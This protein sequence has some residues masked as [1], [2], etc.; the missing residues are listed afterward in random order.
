MP[1]K[2]KLSGHQKGNV[3]IE[4][5]GTRPNS[6][7]SSKNAPDK[8]PWTWS[9]EKP[10]SLR[11]AELEILVSTLKDV[12]KFK[13]GIHDASNLEGDRGFTRW[14]SGAGRQK[15][16][17]RAPF[18]KIDTARQKVA[19]QNIMRQA[20]TMPRLVKP[21]GYGFDASEVGT[22]MSVFG[23]RYPHESSFRPPRSAKSSSRTLVVISKGRMKCHGMPRQPRFRS[24]PCFDLLEA[25]RDW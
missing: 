6:S 2:Q 3:D 21:V 19:L 18:I 14:K 10:A 4:S 13:N 8:L 12:E 7:R 5:E 24:L 15:D 9:K 17:K 1:A 23:S 20:K 25:Y 11:T 22:E 16:W